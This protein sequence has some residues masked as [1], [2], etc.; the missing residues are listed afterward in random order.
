MSGNSPETP[1]TWAE[2]EAE[3]KA[4]IK[5]DNEAAAGLNEWEKEQRE[6]NNPI[7]TP[8][9]E[10][11]SPAIRAAISNRK[12]DPERWSWANGKDD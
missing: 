3:Q 12:N 11:P 8:Q 7:T 4:K 9:P 1:K 5:A 10:T 6:A 2:W